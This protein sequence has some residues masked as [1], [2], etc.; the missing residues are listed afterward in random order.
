MFSASVPPR[1]AGNG[2]TDVGRDRI[3]P[4]RTESSACMFGDLY[5]MLAVGP[6]I[7]FFEHTLHCM[8]Q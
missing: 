5:H 4:L 2:E 1:S 8:R 7:D 3:S 6:S